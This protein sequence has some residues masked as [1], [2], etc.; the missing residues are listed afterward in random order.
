MSIRSL[1][2]LRY[3]LPL[4]IIN[5]SFLFGQ[6]KESHTYDY[7]LKELAELTISTGSIKKE[8]RSSAPSNITII[9]AQMIEERAYRTLVDICQDI[10][11]FDFMVFNDGAGEYT[12][13]NMNRGVGDVGNPEVL[14]LIDGVVQNNIAFNWSTLWG[15]ENTLIDV[16][17]VEIIQ[18]PGSVTYGAQAFTGVIHIITK[19]N[20]DGIAANAWGGSGSTY[21]SELHIGTELWENIRLSLACKNYSSSGDKGAGRYDPGNYFKNI[22]LP[23]ILTRDYDGSGN[24]VENQVNPYAG[25]NIQDGFNTQNNSF[26][27]RSKV[28]YKNTEAGF[29]FSD[30]TRAYGPTVAAYEYNLNDPENTMHFRNYH[31]YVNNSID[32]FTKLTLTSTLVHRAA[33]IIPDGGF[34]YLYQFPNFRKSYANYSNQSYIE[35]KFLYDLNEKNNFSFGIKTNLSKQSNRIISLGEYPTSKT[36]TES[37]WDIAQDGGG[38]DKYKKY[39]NYW[40]TEIAGYALWDYDINGPFSASIGIRYDLNSEYGSIFNPRYAFDFNPSS[41]F[42]VKLIYGR[43]FRQPSVYELYSEFR[44]NASLVPQRIGT[45]EI[46]MHAL[47]FNNKLSVE[48]NIYLSNIKNMIGKID[49]PNKPAG[50]KFDNTGSLNIGGASLY[51]FMQLSRN[52]RSY[53]NYNY[54]TGLSDNSSFYDINRTAKHKVNAGVNVKLYKNKLITDLRINMVGKRKAPETNTWLQTY[55]N[56]FAPSYLKANLTISY[57]LTSSIMAQV[58]VDNLFNERYYGIG[59]ESGSGFIDDYDYINNVNPDGFIPAYHPQ[60]SRSAHLKLTYRLYK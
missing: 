53:I 41:S 39:P 35:E 23:S 16:E 60:P 24:F 19:K 9:T 26:T 18:G 3:T 30:V 1:R 50:E 12:T 44:G 17:R 31:F 14:V 51:S 48:L 47:L 5:I 49:D 42:G 13:Y 27:V 32:L 15:N 46:E 10:P 22:R 6:K 33:N 37:S 20:F 36:S 54:I 25:Q 57:K 7:S 56:G 28:N 4:L 58:L 8:K 43:A 52:I 55:E 38:L 11:G 29:F 2:I 59:R 34:K 40:I 21:A 45:S